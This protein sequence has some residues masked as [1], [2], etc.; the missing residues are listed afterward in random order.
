MSGC[1]YFLGSPVSSLHVP[2]GLEDLNDLVVDLNLSTL[3]RISVGL[4]GQ[5]ITSLL[6]SFEILKAQLSGDNVQISGGANFTLFLSVTS[7]K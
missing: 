4:S 3:V 7:R 1:S 5:R 6:Y 2:A